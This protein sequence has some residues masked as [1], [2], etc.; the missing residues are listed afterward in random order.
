M[1][2]GQSHPIDRRQFLQASAAATAAVASA[3]LV[4]G[5]AS[6]QEA[7]ANPA[8]TTLKTRKLG[9]TGVEVTLLNHGTVGEPAGLARLLRTSYREG[10]RYYDTAEGYKNSEKVIG[11]WLAA[12]PEVRKSIFLATKSH[13]RTPSDMLKKLDQR[14]ALLKTDY[15]DLLFFHGLD[16]SQ[17]DWPKS[18]EL[19]EA[20]EALKKTGKVKFVG[21]ST[22][23]AKIAEQIRN[24]AE[25]GFIDVIMLK[26][27]PWLDRDAPLNKAL[28]A[29]H[30]KGIGLVSMKQLA[31]QTQFTAEHVPSIKAKGLTPAQGLLQAIWTDERF[32]ASC[33]TLRNTEQVVE[34]ADA[35]RRFE[36]LKQ[37]EID[38]LRDAVLASNPTMCPGC[39]GRC[40]LAAGTDAK[41]GDLARFYTY[42]ESHGMRSVARESYAELAEEHRDW[43]GADLAAARE[44][45]HHK[46]DFARILPEVD[47]LL[48]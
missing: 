21:F 9:K 4:A 17:T 11:D 45:C 23:D 10:V 30:A 3:G 5:D 44:A 7:K 29:C 19:K 35:V 26:Y 1:S 25:G 42:H 6:A 31:G 14:L 16:T 40:S 37:A 48:G 38:E 18:K 28:D 2:E 24:A 22:H 34:N 39:D 8:G 15:V 33:V 13:V 43:R 12:E 41:L 36:P 47:R 32:S 27:T 46:L 20:A